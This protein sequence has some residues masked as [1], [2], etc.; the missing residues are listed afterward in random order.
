M[1]QTPAGWYVD[2]Q[3]TTRWWDGYQWTEHTQ[4][5]APTPAPTPQGM[6]GGAGAQSP[7]QQGGEQ[8]GG[9]RQSEVEPDPDRTRIRETPRAQSQYGGGS[10]ASWQPPER[11]SPPGQPQSPPWGPAQSQSSPWGGGAA[12]AV[13]PP[14]PGGPIGS[15]GQWGGPGAPGSQYAGWGAQPGATKSGG[16]RPWMLIVAGI[17]V[18]VVILV[19][20]LVVVLGGGGSSN[21]AADAPKNASVSDFCASMNLQEFNPS[22]TKSDLQKMQDRMR[23]VGTPSNMP[24]AARKG[25]EWLVDVSNASDARNANQSQLAALGQYYVTTCAGQ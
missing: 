15:G 4:P 7:E 14:P 21:N 6:P 25:W 16:V 9:E 10:A 17:A 20:V 12:G 1:S 13:P 5:S 23:Q 22:M 3:G 2:A 11:Q 24:P 19:V 8:Q 18:L